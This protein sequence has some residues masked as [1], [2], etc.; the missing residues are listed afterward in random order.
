MPDGVA[1]AIP[2]YNEVDNIQK[3]VPAIKEKCPAAAVFVIDD[4]SPDGTADTVRRMAREIPGI[5]LIWR[6]QKNGLAAAYLE[7]FSRILGNGKVESIVTMDG[8]LSHSPQD[9]EKILEA[10]KTADLVVGSRYVSGGSIENWTLWRRALSRY[11]NHYARYVTGIPIRD[12]TSGFVFYRRR[13][14]ESILDIGVSSHGYAYQI[15]MKFLA[16][17]RG[18]RVREVP[19]RFCDRG[20]GVSK[21]EHGVVWEGIVRPWALR[22]GRKP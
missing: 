13:V 17:A 19:I 3:L 22:F 6:Q 8:D 16:H 12:L 7:A 18:A 4:N 14:L 11:G 5:E 1:I 10:G 2:T 9:L 20:G 21:L 15:E